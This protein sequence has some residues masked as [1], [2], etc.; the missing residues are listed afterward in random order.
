MAFH[1]LCLRNIEHKYHAR[2]VRT[3]NT[4]AHQRP[5]KTPAYTY[6]G[7]NREQIGWSLV[8]VVLGRTIGSI[9]EQ[10]VD[11]S[12]LIALYLELVELVVGSK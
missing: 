1:F 2:V 9:L 11:D 5:L 7:I 3:E 6:M 8:L 10:K 12:A 4:S